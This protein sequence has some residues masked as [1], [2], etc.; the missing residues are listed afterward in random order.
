MIISMC[1][2]LALYM[3]CQILIQNLIL[4]HGVS[5]GNAAPHMVYLHGAWGGMVASL[6]NFLQLFFCGSGNAWGSPLWKGK[7]DELIN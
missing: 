7:K 5:V 1:L 6:T 3:I 2:N 4:G